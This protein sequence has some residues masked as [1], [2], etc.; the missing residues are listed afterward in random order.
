M[1]R[2]VFAAGEIL[3]AADSNEFLIDQNV[4]SFADS[5]ARGSAIGTAVQGMVTYLNDIDSLSVYNAN[6]WTID[7]TIQVFADST[8]RGSAIGTA[9]EG[10][11]SWL[12]D[13]KR[14]SVY[15]GSSWQSVGGQPNEVF[16]G[17]ETF[18]AVSSVSID[19]VFS[20]D[21]KNY[22]VIFNSR[23]NTND[24][25]TFRFRVR[26]G[27]SDLTSTTYE[28]G[29]YFTGL[30]GSSAGVGNNNS[31][32]ETAALLGEAADYLGYASTMNVYDPFTLSYTKFHQIGGGETMDFSAGVV[33]DSLSYDGCTFFVG[34]GTMTG[35]ISVYGIVES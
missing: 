18:S 34:T 13:S 11:A 4:M 2:K 21:Y 20:A 12:E 15:N 26:A 7:R 27:G 28:Y 19:D 3:T 10:M 30:G 9:V 33:V 16:I 29:R 31:L 8:A 14:L 17:S 25:T 6:D 1:S 24:G 35:T 23:S 32:N 5:T 22:K